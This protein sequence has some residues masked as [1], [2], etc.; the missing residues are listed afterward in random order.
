ME[1]FEFSTQLNIPK[2]SALCLGNFDGVH[3]GHR[4]LFNSAMD[5]KSWGAMVFST[6]FRGDKQLT[7]LK[8]KLYALEKGKLHI[9]NV[10]DSGKKTE[11]DSAILVEVDGIYD[12]VFAT[13]ENEYL[14]VSGL[15]AHLVSE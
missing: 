12:E 7:T 14:L 4:R 11:A 3:L 5:R 13:S 9:M 2:N 10:D 6:N 15:G 1:V 8:E